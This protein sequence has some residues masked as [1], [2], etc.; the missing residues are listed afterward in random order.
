MSKL[1]ARSTA[2]ILAIAASGGVAK[3]Q[4]NGHAVEILGLHLGMTPSEVATTINANLKKHSVQQF[5]G[6]ISLGSYKS[7]EFMTG[8]FFMEDNPSRWNGAPNIEYVTV[9]YSFMDDPHVISID[10]SMYFDKDTAPVIDEL[11]KSVVSKYG[12]PVKTTNYGRTL[13]TWN[14]GGTLKKDASA[15]PFCQGMIGAYGSGPFGFIR[16]FN[17]GFRPEEVRRYPECATTMTLTIDQLDDNKSLAGRI[18]FSIGDL[19]AIGASY[20]ATLKSMNA[21]AAA[22]DEAIKKRASQ[23]A[24]KL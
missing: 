20:Q 21:N 8:E 9:E 4:D 12:T 11:I 3:A 18:V 15:I 16:Q 2:A 22:S 10:R 1:L 5:R 24:P 13:I 17:F 23:N 19:N 6:S 7:P 14:W